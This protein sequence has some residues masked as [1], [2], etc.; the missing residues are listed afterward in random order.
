M[1][2]I[3]ADAGPLIALA[4]LNLLNLPTRL[5]GEAIVP[6]TVF[7]ECQVEARHTDAA[8]IAGA[9]AGGLLTLRPDQPWPKDHAPPAIDKGELA[10]LALA[11]HLHAPLLID[12]RKG[13]RAAHGLGVA[14]TGVCGVL[15]AAQREGMVSELA[16]LLELLERQGYYI[17]DTLR[18][19]VLTAAGE[20]AQDD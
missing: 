12:D 9:V 6:E 13:R 8:L 7:G 20:V 16:P 4:K 17:A 14:V 3:V 5:F 2:C 19:K 10:A 15:L 18:T 11:L 1:S